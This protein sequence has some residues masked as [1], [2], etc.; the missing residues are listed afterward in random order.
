MAKT[1]PKP[2]P[3]ANRVALISNEVLDRHRYRLSLNAH[4]LLFGLAQLVDHTLDLFPTYEIDIRGLW[5]Y[6][7]IAD[8]NDRYEVVRDSLIELTRNPLQIVISKKKWMSIPWM[9][10]QY[11]EEKSMYVKIRFVD[12]VK[13][14][15]L[16][17]SEYTKIKG[18]YIAKL[19]STYAAWLY[20]VLKMIQ[21]KY[22]GHHAIAIQRLKEMTFT[23]D[24][25]E[26]PAYNKGTAAVSHFLQR[27]IGLKYHRAEKRYV[28]VEGSPLWEIN[29]KTDIRVTAEPIKEGRAYAAIMFHV[30]SNGEE[31]R[32]KKAVDK[33]R[34]VDAIP[35]RE[36]CGYRVPVRNIYDIAKAQG[37][38]PAECARRMGYVID[39]E[40][41]YLNKTKEQYERERE[42]QRAK[43][44]KQ[45]TYRQLTIEEAIE[46]NLKALK[47]NGE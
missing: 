33:S 19:S 39:G 14:F 7:G 20:P 37:I 42:E 6:L 22:Y 23:D 43:Q 46:R 17:L 40:Y 16:R 15:L 38:S 18:L 26:Y 3:T 44:L 10:V 8:R 36:L 31:K 1:K 2:K 12:E 34:Y 47:P 28:I 41:A 29:N 13:P 25:R 5:D 32:A 45:R 21:T 4:K 11:D 24:P 27:V 9:S 35:Q 30:V